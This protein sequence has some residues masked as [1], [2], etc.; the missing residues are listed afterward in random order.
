MYLLAVIPAFQPPRPVIAQLIQKRF[1]DSLF[2]GWERG[3]QFCPVAQNM[4]FIPL[5]NPVSALFRD[6]QGHLSPVLLTAY[7][8]DE[9]FVLQFGGNLAHLSLIN[10]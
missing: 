7:P 2:L 5:G 6:G 1:Q 9:T 3:K 10:I 8:G 4:R